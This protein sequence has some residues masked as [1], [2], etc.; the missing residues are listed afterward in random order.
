M[1][2]IAAAPPNRAAAPTAPVGMAPA[3]M[4]EE[5]LLAVGLPAA[6]LPIAPVFVGK[7]E[8]TASLELVRAALV[9]VGE[10]TLEVKG[11]SLPDEAPG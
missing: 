11:T 9:E 8:A 6:L 10:G 3:A 7:P 5:L 4:P 2:R 1:F